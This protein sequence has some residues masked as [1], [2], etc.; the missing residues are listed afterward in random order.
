MSCEITIPD[1]HIPFLDNYPNCKIRLIWEFKGWVTCESISLSAAKFL[2]DTQI[3]YSRYL[4]DVHAVNPYLR[5]PKIKEILNSTRL[6]LQIIQC[7]DLACLS[8][9]GHYKNYPVPN[10]ILP[11]SPPHLLINMKFFWLVL[12]NTDDLPRQ[13]RGWLLKKPLTR[14]MKHSIWSAFLFPFPACSN[15]FKSKHSQRAKTQC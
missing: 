2:I 9:N 15:C 13:W 10:Y 12:V 8:D 11:I 14:P 7:S 5:Y 6:R 3:A 4:P 1:Y